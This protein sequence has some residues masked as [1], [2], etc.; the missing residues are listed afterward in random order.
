MESKGR[1]LHNKAAQAREKGK[2]AESLIFNDRALFAYDTDNDSLGFAEGIA[3]RSITLR[4]Y[5]GL[6][7]SRRFLTL[8]KY[9]MLGAVSIARESGDKTALALPLYNLAQLQEDLGELPSAVTT[10]KEAA[11]QMQQ[12]P[13]AM[14]NRPSVLLNMKIHA[15]VCE[16]KAGDKSALEKAEKSLI[17]LEA[18]DESNTF[19]HDVW[20]SGGHMRIAEALADNPDRAHKHLE[21]AKKIID[22]NPE[23]ILRKQ[24]WERLTATFEEK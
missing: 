5:A 7:A 13:P 14:H 19:N 8:A 24:Q 23:L 4:V 1:Q 2:F 17:D 18:A 21:D 3:C 6:R 10:Y 16:Y 9:E 12:N 15:Q 11:Q 22:A 20:V